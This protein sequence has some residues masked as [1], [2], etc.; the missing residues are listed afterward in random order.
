M[1]G[2]T[3]YR[4]GGTRGGASEFKWEN[5]KG[6][7]AFLGASMYAHRTGRKDMSRD[8][9]WYN[10]KEDTLGRGLQESHSAA[11]RRLEILERQQADAELLSDALGETTERRQAA[12]KVEIAELK[13]LVERGGTERDR[14]DAERVVGLGAAPARRHDHIVQES[15]VA[16][17]IERQAKEQRYDELRHA[18]AAR[19]RAMDP[20]A[21]PKPADAPQDFVHDATSKKRKKKRSHEAKKKKKKKH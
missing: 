1:F 14:L 17:E 4:D 19:R 15:R 10:K 2:K 11:R 18:D 5:V 3:G 16:T 21:L 12:V 7:D 8:F 20:A 9:F 6:D 13:K